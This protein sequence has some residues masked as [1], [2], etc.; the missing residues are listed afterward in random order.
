MSAITSVFNDGIFAEQFERY[1]R[2]PASVDETWRQYFRMAESLLGQSAASAP[3]A[4]GATTDVAYLQKVAGAASLQQAIR[5]YGHY[6]VPLDPLGA[7]PIGA[8]ELAP[9]FHGLTEDDLATIPGAAIGDDRYATAKDVIARKREVYT[10][11]IGYE[12]WHLEVNEERNWF[13]HAFR[14]GE[15]TRPLT[16]DE[17]KAVLRRLNEVDG[18]ERFL[19]RAYQ[20]YK[21][22]SVEGNDTLVPM[23]DEMINAL[24][25]SGA[26][27]IVIGMAHR[28]RLNVLTNVMGKP[29][30]TLFAEFEGRH[31]HA[32]ETATGDVKY[33]AGFTGVR[34][35][36]GRE[37]KLRLVPNPSHLEVVNP[38][39][40]GVVR[41]RQR[42]AG[43]PGER[44][45]HAVVPVAI[46]G[47][48]AFPGEGIVA[49]TLNISHLNAYRTGGTIHIIVNNQVGFTTD[50]GDARS[51]YYSS[52]LAKGFEIP[53]FHVNADDAE[54]CITAM[55]LACAYRT[56]FKK[57]VLIDLVGYRRHGHNEG[58][59]PMYTQP[60]RTTAIRKH[61]TV[62]QVWATRLVKEGVLTADE[63]AAV[64]KD[65]SQ[66]Y[67]DIHSAFKQS[68]LSSEKHAPWPAEPSPASRVVQTNVAAERLQFVNESLLQWPQEFTPNPR[69]AKQL[70]RRR[71]TMGEQGGIEWGHAE[72]L[73]FGTL[74]LDGMSVRITGQD[75]E[76]GTFS[77]RH[78]VLNDANSG[79]KYAPLAN[80]P[81]SKGIFEVYNSAL[82][83]TAVLAFEYGFSTVASD[84]L[85]LWEA[86]FGDFVNVA[87][88]IID[89]FIVA[90]RAKWGQDSGLVM[91]LPHGYE[92]Q[93]PEH[94]SARLERFLQLCA[95][96]NMTVAY[97]ST[98]A[99]FFHLLRRQA[100]RPNRRPLICMQPKSMLRLP[101]ASSHLDDLVHGGFQSVIDDPIAS[102]RRD[103]V[104][105]IVFCTGKVYY[106]MAL[107]ANRNPNVAL[108]RVEELYSW[109][110]EEIQRIM[111]LYPAIEQVVWAQEE[112][113]NQ[114]AWTYVQPRLR[115]SAG[116][117]VGVRY[118]GRPERASPAE[119]YADAHQ[120]EQAR[121]IA[122]VMDTGEVAEERPAMTISK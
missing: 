121:I 116:A 60:T 89:Q 119:G 15:L 105:R 102:Q 39:I 78:S 7:P 19:G 74:L 101:Q 38:V 58:D 57:D 66:R 54:S 86:Q 36:D 95:E 63:A 26:E 46:H 73:A 109:P 120:Q 3:A 56:M 113:K 112:P 24:G 37:V 2:D 11:R 93:G 49:E 97:C 100:L 45:E 55:R 94:S 76:R 21:R 50:P 4:A 16:V 10:T 72:A 81:G 69:L 114:G 83:E 44:N 62:P 59:E 12:V 92:G 77:H 70:E 115:A 27:E 17:K 117:A 1:R 43:K 42:V 14:A 85:T 88:P 98:P 90:D 106:D 71:E 99:Q 51:T 122:M 118:V 80:I 82:S 87:Q 107:A 22:F 5:M 30:E 41:A 28:G 79:R 104:R 110:H 6:D 23:L 35:V 68:L 108:V 33:H 34:S 53:I 40:E 48:A 91:L 52:D 61:P 20:G 111:D 103:D 18:L 25:K 67:A 31:D 8:D 75:A 64:E 47:D 84:T 13:R 65:V 9:G 32:D 29:F 96:G